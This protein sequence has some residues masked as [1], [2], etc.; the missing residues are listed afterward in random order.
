M[1]VYKKLIWMLAN[2]GSESKLKQSLIS[3]ARK[4]SWN[5]NVRG[6]T[7]SSY[8]GRVSPEPP[9]AAGKSFSL[10]R[11]SLIGRTVSS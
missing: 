5:L 3:I 10:G 9:I 2:S 1:S 4:A 6:I 11:P 8:S 7:S